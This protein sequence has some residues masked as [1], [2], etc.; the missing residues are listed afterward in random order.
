MRVKNF[1]FTVSLGLL[2]LIPAFGKAEKALGSEIP[3]A[4]T[5][6]NVRFK[7]HLIAPKGE[8]QC[9]IAVMYADFSSSN[10]EY[11][12]L[13]QGMTANASLLRLAPQAAYT[14]AD[15]H[16]AGVR[17]QYTNVTGMLDATTLDLLGN[18]SMSLDNLSA[19]SRALSASAFQRTY[20]GLDKRGRVG[21]FWDYILG[22]TRKNV[23]FSAGSGDAPYTITHKI[24]LGFAPGLVYFPMNNVSVQASICLADFAYNYSKAYENNAV[25]G[26]RHAWKAQA[27]I[28]LL[29]L[30]FGLTIH[31]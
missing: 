2:T 16:A 4:D 29:D 23:S 14:F 25:V 20:W 21:L 27:N 3:P 24:H 31:F 5:T 17:F 30:N 8:W 26:H 9:G 28:N 19:R 7:N 13:M 1:I 12:M 10:S 18:F 15:N 6:K 11:M 22:Y